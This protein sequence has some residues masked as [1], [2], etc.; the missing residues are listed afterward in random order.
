[1]TWPASLG[2]GAK[3]TVKRPSAS[4]VT[5]RIRRTP[6]TMTYTSAST[7]PIGTSELSRK[8]RPANATGCPIRDVAWAGSASSTVARYEAST[9]NFS[10]QAVLLS[11]LTSRRVLRGL[12]TTAKRQLAPGAISSGTLRRRLALWPTSRP[13]T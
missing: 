5:G 10:D 4:L 7:W 1:M 13:P 11:R 8:V 9:V 6:L 2:S 12:T 3:S